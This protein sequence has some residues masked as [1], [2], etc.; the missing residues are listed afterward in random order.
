MQC[1]L[2]AAGAAA[3]PGAVIGRLMGMLLG[4]TALRKRPLAVG[5]LRAVT[6]SQSAEGFEELR[7]FS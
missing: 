1:E 3:G 7:A 6:L 4:A 2:A 5:T